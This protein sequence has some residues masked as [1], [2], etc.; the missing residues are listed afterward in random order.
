MH[1]VRTLLAFV[2]FS[3]CFVA[4]GYF[5]LVALAG[6]G[7]RF[8]QALAAINARTSEI[9]AVTPSARVG[10]AMENSAIAPDP[11]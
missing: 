7:D 6:P 2:I 3:A 11:L 9:A 1:L 5:G 8:E 10:A 4:F